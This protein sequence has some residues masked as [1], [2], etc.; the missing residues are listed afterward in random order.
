MKIIKTYLYFLLGQILDM[1]KNITE[2]IT[3]DGPEGVSNLKD[4]SNPSHTET[5]PI[6]APPMAICSGVLLNLLAVNA[7][8]INR[9]VISKIPTIFIDKEII[10]E[11]MIMKIN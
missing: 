4:A 6:N 9:D 8:I 1:K 2:V 11:I 5:I 7:G 3:I 10:A